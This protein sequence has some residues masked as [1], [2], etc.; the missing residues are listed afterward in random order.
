MGSGVAR[1]DPTHVT[2]KV[3][4]VCIPCFKSIAP[5][6]CMAKV[7]FLEFFGPDMNTEMG[8]VIYMYLKHPPDYIDSKYIWIHGLIP[9][10][11]VFMQMYLLFFFA[12]LAIHRI[13]KRCG[14]VRSSPCYSQ[15]EVIYAH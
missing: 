1:R 5:R 8:V 4:C 2:P 3:I 7:Q 13:R 6:V 11:Q 15:S 12:F 10:V 9:K 14:K